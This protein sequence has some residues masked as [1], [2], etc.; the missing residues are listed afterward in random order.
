MVRTVGA[1]LPG[2]LAASAACSL[3][4]GAATTSSRVEPTAAAAA[5][6]A[7]G[8]PRAGLLDS[9]LAGRLALWGETAA[10]VADNTA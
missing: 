8:S 10:A 6:G 1:A 2:A 3:R 9:F 7:L 5:H 4:A